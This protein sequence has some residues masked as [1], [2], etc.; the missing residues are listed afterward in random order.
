MD[1]QSNNQRKIRGIIKGKN[2]KIMP[3]YKIA[4]VRLD[5][6]KIWSN[7]QQLK[8]QKQEERKN[9]KQKHINTSNTE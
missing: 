1:D 7:L 3:D 6:D 9:S 4:V 5:E 8:R 2:D